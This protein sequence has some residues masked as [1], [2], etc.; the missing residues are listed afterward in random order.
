LACAP[1]PASPTAETV[2]E[3]R[4]RASTRT[5][6]NS[7]N[8]AASSSYRSDDSAARDELDRT[9]EAAS[10]AELVV[11]RSASDG[12][13]LVRMLEVKDQFYGAIFAGRE[14]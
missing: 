1:D 7:H 10:L 4:R 13:D 11:A 5:S 14:H 3:F 12:T 2:A 9:A 8:R 6:C